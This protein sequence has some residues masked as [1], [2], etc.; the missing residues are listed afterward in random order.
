MLWL[1]LE[2]GSS[3]NS[4]LVLFN[5]QDP[6]IDCSGFDMST[7]VATKRFSTI[8]EAFTGFRIYANSNGVSF[9]DAAKQCVCCG[10]PMMWFANNLEAT[11]AL[12]FIGVRALANKQEGLV[13]H[14]FIMAGVRDLDDDGM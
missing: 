5:S 10:D 8:T 14:K 13:A 2:R 1:V 4:S 12:T 6:D 3:Y 9:T 7:C 11:A